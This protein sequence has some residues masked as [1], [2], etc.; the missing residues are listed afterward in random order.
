MARLHKVL[1]ILMLMFFVVDAKHKKQ[2]L[3]SKSKL[4]LKNHIPFPIFGILKNDFEI[5]STGH[6]EVISQDSGVSAM[7]INL[8]PTNKIV[9]YDATIYRLSRLKYPNRAPCVT[10]QDLKTKENKLDCFAHSMEYDL[11]T[12]QVRPLKVGLIITHIFVGL[13]YIIN[14]IFLFF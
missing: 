9:V 13:I 7:Q 2:R 5:D 3:K 11:E 14:L 10:F 1:L 4:F 8:M 6:W 12:N